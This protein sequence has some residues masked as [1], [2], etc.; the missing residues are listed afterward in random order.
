MMVDLIGPR[1]QLNHRIGHPG[2][3][4]VIGGIADHD[5]KFIT[6]KAPAQFVV[7]DN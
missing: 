6:A 3:A 7:G 4:V 1:Q 5:G 2:H